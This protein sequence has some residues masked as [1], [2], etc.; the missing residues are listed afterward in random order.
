MVAALS[1]R[2]RLHEPHPQTGSTRCLHS[3]EQSTSCEAQLFPGAGTYEGSAVCSGASAV[4]TALGMLTASGWGLGGAVEAS[5]RTRRTIPAS[6]A[7]AAPAP[8]IS[9]GEGPRRGAA[10]GGGASAGT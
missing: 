2:Q 9:A 3:P 10:R 5:E 6:A 1:S 7:T 8:P 4:T